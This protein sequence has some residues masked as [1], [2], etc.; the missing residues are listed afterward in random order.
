VVVSFG[1]AISC[2]EGNGDLWGMIWEICELEL[3]NYALPM[4]VLALGACSVSMRLVF[5]TCSPGHLEWV[6][7]REDGD[8]KE[9][10]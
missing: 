1:T 3:H 2:L 7:G 5:W 8:D 6:I 9:F 10:I 4:L